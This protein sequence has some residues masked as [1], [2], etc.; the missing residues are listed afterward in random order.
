MKKLLRIF[1]F[2]SPLHANIPLYIAFTLLGIV[3]SVANFAMIMPLLDVLFN[4]LDAERIQTLSAKPEFTITLDFLINYFNYHFINIILTE[5]KIQAL[6]FICLIL[7]SSVLITNFFRYL[8]AIIS[9]KIRLKIL[10][11]IRL[12]IFKNISGMHMGFFSNKK[13][14]DII[15]R[16]TNDVNEIELTVLHTLRSLTKEPITILVFFGVLFMISFK[17]TLITLIILPLTGGVIGEVV[18][19]LK[20]RA[21]ES[22]E[23]VGRVVNIVDETLAGIR[24]IKAFNALN[25]IRGKFQ[26]EVD[27]HQRVNMS[28][29]YKNELGSPMS[30][31]LGVLI[32]SGILFYGGSMV[33]NGPS[34]SLTASEF[35]AYIAIYSQI[36][37]PSKAFARGI[38]DIQKGLASADRIFSFV[39]IKSEIQDVANPKIISTFEKS[40]QFIDVNFSYQKEDVLK[41]MNLTIEKGKTLALVGPSGGGKSTIADLTSRFY[42]PDEGSITIDGIP[43]KDCSLE[44]LRSLMG[45]VTQESILFHDTLFNNIAFGIEGATQEDVE[46]AAKVA[47]AHDFIKELDKGYETVIGDRGTKLSGGQ[48]Q[49]ISIARAVLKN[50]PIL[51]LDEATSALDSESEKLVQDALKNVLKNRTSLV[52]AHRLSTIQNADEIIVIDKGMIIEKGTHQELLSHE[53]LYKKLSSIQKT[54]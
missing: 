28:I 31:F 3:F 20:K 51:I 49:R 48:R 4:Q 44:S 52:I 1:S 47:N 12:E 15:S 5:G 10:R 32:I 13:R 30:E 37:N 50:P 43:V 27:Y 18:R 36:L 33:L 29:A 26:K 19:R 34:D 7:I 17:L 21:V 42:D 23:S 39:D 6:L 45:I 38:S 54:V 46:H 8:A 22:Q 35:I 16:I 41:K 2:A 25:Y 11:N 53:G 9:A 24:V 14:G 40:I